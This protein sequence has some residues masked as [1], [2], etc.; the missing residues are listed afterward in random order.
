[1]LN[2]IL[3]ERSLSSSKKKLAVDQEKQVSFHRRHGHL[4]V[5]LHVKKIRTL[6]IVFKGINLFTFF[7]V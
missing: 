1:M 6:Q 5:L 4:K 7:V 2:L 3:Q